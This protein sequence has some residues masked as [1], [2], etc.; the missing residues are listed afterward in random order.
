MVDFQSRTTR[1]DTADDD[2]SVADDEGSNADEDEK[3][4]ED[5]TG[6]ADESDKREPLDSSDLS[7]A[8]V[9][10]AADRTL[11]EDAQG[12]VVAEAIEAD[13][14]TVT[15]R[16]LL[17]PAVEPIRQSVTSLS[18]RT[19]VDVVVTIGGTGV[20]PDD[21]TVEALEPL[22]EKELPGFGE[23][24]RLLAH[25]SAGSAVV[26]TRCTAGIFGQV[27]V[28]VLPGTMEGALLGT[29]E[30]VLPEAWSLVS[31]ARGHSDEQSSLE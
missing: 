17:Q 6:T 28:F 5:S 10:I 22:F 3:T 26:G 2:E 27:P 21:V 31:D 12:D 25:E 8:V 9:T 15:T 1:R 20:E 4:P 11:S 18:E 13:G 23:L 14:N 7:V 24:F 16:E 30:I 19:D 29:D